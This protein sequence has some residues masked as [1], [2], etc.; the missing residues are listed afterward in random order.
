[1]NLNADIIPSVSLGGFVI[2]RPISEY[3]DYLEKYYLLNKLDYFQ[4]DIYS[5]QYIVTNVPVE[6]YV[7]IRDGRIYKISAVK[8]YKGKYA[9]LIKVGMSA[10]KILELGKHFYYD[11]C[12]QGIFSNEIDGIVFELNDEDPYYE[13]IESL[14]IEAITVFNPK[15]FKP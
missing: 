8:G 3:L 5:V 12:D 10:Q 6:V 4:T 7:D 2:G 13:E 11:E 14:N 1:M 15:I 9:D